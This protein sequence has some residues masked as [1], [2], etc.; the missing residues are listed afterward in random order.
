[1]SDT[2]KDI[3][4]RGKL[5]AS[6]LLS[7]DAV[8]RAAELVTR[9]EA[10]GIE[11][12]RL[13]FPDQHGI[14]RGKTVAA[15]T[16]ASAFASG[17]G[18]PST[19]L[20]KDTSH[21]TVFD[22]WSGA[23]EVDGLGFQGASDVLL[24]PDPDAFHL[25]SWSPHSAILLC[26]VVQRSGA[27]VH[28]ASRTVLRTATEKLAEAGFAATMGLEVEFQVYQRVDDGLDHAQATMPG[29]PVTT[30]NTSQGYQYLTETRYAEAEDLLDELRRAAEVM[31]LAPRSMEIEMGPSQYEFTFDASDPMGQADRMVLFRTLVKEVCQR[32]G[33]HGSF[34]AKPK[35]PNASAN[36]WHIHQSLQTLEGA[37]VFVS[38]ADGVPTAEASAWIAGLLDNAAAACLMTTPTV[39]G[40]K[41]YAPFQLAPNRIQWGTDNRGAMIRALLFAGDPASRIENRAPDTTANPYYALAAQILSGLDGLTRGAKAPPATD[42]PYEG[43]DKLPP[44]LIAAIETFETSTLFRQALG[45]GFVSYLAHLK[46]AEWDR[47]LMT[48]SEW[49]QA[50]YFNLF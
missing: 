26:D 6:G 36:G 42:K 38:D 30:R 12:V 33:L 27:P 46:R 37:N 15:R 3:I 48:V 24:V 13:M 2:P 23:A 39:N 22:V 20:L 18:V 47:Y 25:L 19:L 40:Y 49:E 8:A 45:D 5:A 4:G 41:R 44:S 14:L 34:M 21:R 43:A 7:D 31:G 32:R 28:F 10:E 9:C 16:L 29:A 1:M 11:T 35:L 17:I 50:E